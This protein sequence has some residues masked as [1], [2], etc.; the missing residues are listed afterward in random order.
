M[1]DDGGRETLIQ[2]RRAVRAPATATK[3]D[4]EGIALFAPGVL[5]AALHRAAPARRSAFAEERRIVAA[6]KAAE[7]T[8][9]R[10]VCIAPCSRGRLA[11]VIEQTGRDPCTSQIAARR[12]DTFAI[13]LPL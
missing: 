1:P 12:D 7:C 8:P 2:S 3:L 10:S 5:S 9:F 13:Q 11:S 6:V 4:L